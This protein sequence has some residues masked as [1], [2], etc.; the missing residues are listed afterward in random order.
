MQC[1]NPCQ[2]LPCLW[3][4]T[5]RASSLWLSVSL[6]LSQGFVAELPRQVSSST[7]LNYTHIMQHPLCQALKGMQECIRQGTQNIVIK[8]YP[9][10]FISC[11][12]SHGGII[13]RTSEHILPLWL[14][15]RK[16][17]FVG[18]D[19]NHLT[20]LLYT[21]SPPPF[22]NSPHCHREFPNQVFPCY[23]RLPPISC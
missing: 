16:L 11:L 14:K 12:F 17:A 13:T 10:F 19:H 21:H 15:I 8:F 23:L 18:F 1:P 6:V 9:H 7:Q 20:D 2:V 4:V 5:G 22:K 3:G